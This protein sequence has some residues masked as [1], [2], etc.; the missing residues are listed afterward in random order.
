MF[1]GI[2]TH[3]GKIKNKEK[4]SFIIEADISLVHKLEKGMSISVDGICLTVLEKPVNTDFSVEV[5]PETWKRTMLGTLKENS[6]VN[7]ELPVT[8]QA[9]VSGSP[10]REYLQD[11]AVQKIAVKERGLQTIR[12]LAGENTTSSIIPKTQTLDSIDFSPQTE[13]F[14]S[15]HLV[16]G[17]VDGVGIVK[18][19][20][21][22]GNSRILTI[23]VSANLNRYIVEKGFIAIN[24]I[25]LTV[26]DVGDDYFIVGIIPFTWEHTMLYTIQEED[27]INI[28]IDILAKYIEKMY[29]GVLVPARG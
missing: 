21:P 14:L 16:Q 28:E 27:Q 5:M 12:K 29:G 25:S 18:K 3:I 15:G 4:S 19:I 22:E 17:H 2:I 11:E 24:G 23:E 6:I 10:V 7:L 1:T 9:L 26:I 13:A 8:T 20:T